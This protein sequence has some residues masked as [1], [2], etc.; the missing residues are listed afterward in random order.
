VKLLAD[1]NIAPR[2]VSFLCAKGHDVV[3]A[4]DAD[5]ADTAIVEQARQ[6]GRVVLT[7]DLD[8]SA[9]VALSGRTDPSVISLR[10]GSSRIEDVN[11]RLETVLPA[12][13]HDV[14]VGAIVTVEDGRVRSRLL[15][16]G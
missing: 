7:Q 11:L 6:Q 9:I 8:F 2:T 14:S 1:L 4:S 5:G 13:V 3:R 12:I 16:I 10:L 15:P